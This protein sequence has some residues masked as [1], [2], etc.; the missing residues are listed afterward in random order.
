MMSEYTLSQPDPYADPLSLNGRAFWPRAGAYLVDLLVFLAASWLIGLL[1]GFVASFLLILLGTTPHVDAARLD[2]IATL[3][4][5]G[6]S[7][8]YFALGEW[9][10]GATPGK[11]LLGMRVVAVDGRPCGVAAALL[12]GVLRFIDGLF[13][14][15][16]ALMSMREPPHQR[17]GDRA[18]RTLVVAAGAPG[19]AAPR[20]RWASLVA[21]AIWALGYGLCLVVVLLLALPS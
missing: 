16:P 15:L 7:V 17:L 21:L 14:C 20:P 10:G 19:L 12:R 4:S 13:F 8:A 9:L 5:L 1:A 3:L 2:G 11:L 18:A 6:A